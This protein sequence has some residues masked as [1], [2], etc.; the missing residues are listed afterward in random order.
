MDEVLKRMLNTAPDPKTK[1]SLAPKKFLVVK[2]AVG[3][4][5]CHIEGIANFLSYVDSKTLSCVVHGRLTMNQLAR[6]KVDLERSQTE[7]QTAL[8]KHD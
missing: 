3:C 7:I 4:P 6:C 5:L 1:P 2:R 8:Q